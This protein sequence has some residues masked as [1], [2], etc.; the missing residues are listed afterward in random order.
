MSTESKSY[1]WLKYQWCCGNGR[2][3]NLANRQTVITDTS[4]ITKA[5]NIGADRLKH[6][7]SVVSLTKSRQ[8]TKEKLDQ[9]SN[10]SLPINPKTPLITYYLVTVIL[11]K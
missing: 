11:V 3:S 7:F 4:P 10:K 1:K 9:Q 8:S 5:L 2:P 6:N